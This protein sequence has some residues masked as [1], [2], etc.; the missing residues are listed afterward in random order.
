MEPNQNTETSNE[1]ATTEPVSAEVPESTEATEATDAAEAAPAPKPDDVKAK[2]PMDH[3]LRRQLPGHSL[4]GILAALK[5]LESG[6]PVPYLAF[7]G[8]DETEGLKSDDLY[9]LIDLRAEWEEIARKQAH[10][11]QE[12]QTQGK[13]TDELKQLIERSADLDRLEDLYAPFKLKR[14]TLGVQA[15]EAG[16]GVLADY[17]WAIAHGETPDALPGNTLEEVAAAFAKPETKYLDAATVLKGVQDI[18]VE[19]I[20]EAFELRS[21]VRST[22]LRRSKIRAAKG[23]KAKPNSKYGKFFEYQEPIGSLKKGS[24]A[25]RYLAMRR[26][27]LEDELVLSF[28]RPDEGALLEKF[29][30]LAS[31]SKE[32]IGR[33]VLVQAARLALKGNVYTVME[34]EAHRH[35]KEEAE[36]HVIQTL[37]EN[38]RKKLLR[39]GMGRK[40]VMGIDPGGGNHPCSLALVDA[41]GKVIVN[42]NFKLE[43]A[44]T[45][46]AAEFLASLEQL[47][48]EAIAVAHGPRSKEVREAFQKILAGRPLP[49]VSVHEHTSSVYSSS[50]AAKE[51]FPQLD[52]NTRRAVFVARYLQDPLAVILRLDPK[53]LSLGEFQHEV[54]Q[55]DLRRALQRAIEASV[56]FAGIDPN[57]APMHVLSKVSGVST[58]NAKA[59]VQYRDA[60]GKLK[61]RDGLKAVPSLASHFDHCAGFLHIRDSAEKLDATFVHPKHYEAVKAFALQQGA[62]DATSLT[63]EQAEGAATNEA[64][65]AQIGATNAK[66]YSYE[67]AH[68][69]EDPR[70]SFAIFEYQADLK[71]LSDLKKDT[72]YPGVVTNVTSFGAFVDIGIEQD[73][74]VH[75]SEL[76]DALAKNPF[77]ALFPGDPVTV[78]VSAVNEEK[79]Q[80]SLT[81]RQGGGAG[82]R[83]GRGGERRPRGGA[84]RPARGERR[85]RG[86][87]PEGE[88]PLAAGAEGA[89]A[90]GGEQRQ[91][92]PRREPRAP[93]AAPPDTRPDP[94][95]RPVLKGDLPPPG[96]RPEARGD[97]RGRGGEGRG[98]GG[99]REGGNAGGG[100][101][102]RK[103][104]KPQRDTKTGA[105]VKMDD[106]DKA[107]RGGPKL[108]SK[109]PPMAFNP[110][111][112]LGSLLKNKEEK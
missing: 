92:R 1:Q 35:M 90:Q 70:G 55:G 37:A 68:A 40:A 93:R 47:K 14:Q 87:R 63:P 67:L 20:A 69:G 79:K 54:N 104:K 41:D 112:N 88:A 58:E 52:V 53:F 57:F 96:S 65:M 23:P 3:W 13:L 105:I 18:F 51:E 48:I 19:R 46:L 98:R 16:L 5:Q 28:D 38:L 108:P 10:L 9:R 4:R 7:Y 75:I 101:D 77:D 45:S 97:D 62:A 94:G 12:I 111:A 33:E 66:H 25:H 84:G 59:L 32:N 39:P 102:D 89:P 110:F 109:A 83:G 43:E 78:F 21:L 61:N 82:A 15:R 29:E 11:L 106:N 24:S 91:R 6:V 99:P 50:P 71:T 36:R 42:M 80:I 49:I 44:E 8:A 100:R 107:A 74:L 31:P 17:L 73:G 26:G 22:V 85:P 64:L 56:N 60:S 27:W 95:T 81:M 2:T 30:E 103:P 72:A 34:N 86:P 76:T